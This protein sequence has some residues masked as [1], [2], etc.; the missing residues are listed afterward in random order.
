MITKRFLFLFI[1]W[2]SFCTAQ[3]YVQTNRP[4]YTRPF[5]KYN[6]S[7]RKRNF[8]ISV[9]FGIAYPTGEYGSKD[10]AHNFMIIGP[11]S[12]NAKGFANLGFHANI[13]AGVFISK[14][15]GVMGKFALDYNT[16]DVSTLNAYVNGLNYQYTL[17]EPFYIKQYMLGLFGNFKTNPTTT[18]WLQGMAGLISAN[19]PAFTVTINT[20]N[21]DFNL[22]DANVFA[23]SLGLGCE[24]M[25]SHS[26]GFLFNLT[27]T[28]SELVYPTMSYNRYYNPPPYTQNTPV[29]MAFGSLD[30][31]IGVVFHL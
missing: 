27:Y 8:F 25:I 2:S 19:F 28:G 1:L 4:N 9:A 21:F 26:T 7:L 31:T 12:T 13:S 22:E 3:D 14:H 30:F 16:F 29:T 18:I 11:D 24:K 6:D 20:Y 10:T 23:Y 5:Q 15:V 17:N